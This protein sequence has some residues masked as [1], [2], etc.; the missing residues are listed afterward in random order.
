VGRY[1]SNFSIKLKK[2][3]IPFNDNS[4]L[5]PCN[6]AKLVTKAQY[7]KLINENNNNFEKMMLQ[8]Q[9]SN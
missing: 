9:K 5:Q 6:N 1:N 4:N 3:Q 2:I 7:Q 8:L